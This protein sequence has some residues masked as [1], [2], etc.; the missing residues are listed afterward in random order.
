MGGTLEMHINSMNNR[1]FI[2]TPI[3]PIAAAGRH[4]WCRVMNPGRGQQPAVWTIAV[5][6]YDALSCRGERLCVPV[7]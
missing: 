3:K 4:G 1:Q 7:I 2:P 6:R 5:R